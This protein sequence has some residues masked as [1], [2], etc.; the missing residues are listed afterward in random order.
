MN[1]TNS[2]IQVDI[3]NLGVFYRISI[4][5][6]HENELAETILTL[7]ADFLTKDEAK[8]YA[9]T[10]EFKRILRAVTPLPK[11]G[12]AIKHILALHCKGLT[13]KAIISLGFNR[14]TVNRQVAEY[15]RKY[16]FATAYEPQ[17][18]EE[19]DED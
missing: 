14:S 9:N 1:L 2:D 6:L 8:E 18:E 7:G 4:I 17:E 11:A 16:T 5:K 19:Y 15:K 10:V 3:F 12:G 13:N